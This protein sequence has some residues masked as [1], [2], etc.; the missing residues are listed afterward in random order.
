ML[1][2]YNSQTKNK[3][4]FQPLQTGKVQLYVCGS[5]VYDYCHLGHARMF[6]AFDLVVRYLR[7]RDYDV[8]YVRNITDIDDKIIARA[9]ENHE[10]IQAL[11]ERF[12]QAM[13]DD[14]AKL[15]LLSPDQEPKATEFIQPII[16]MISILIEKGYAYH[17]DHGDVLYAVEKFKNYGQLAHKDLEHLQVG[18]RVEVTEQKRNPLD[19]V[20]WK[21][22][23]PNEP[24]WDSP[25]GKGRPGWHIECSAMSTRCLAPHFDIHGGGGDLK[26]PHHENEVA[27]S[28]AATGE[29]FVNYWMHVGFVQ[30][31]K[32]KMSKSLGN[33]FTLR[34]VLQ[35][36]HPEILRYF[37]LASHYRSP[38]NYSTESLELAR[39]ALE[40]FYTSLRDVPVV[41]VVKGT[42][43]ER[44]FMQTM[45]DDFN[46]PEALAVL[47]DLT[48]EINRLKTEGMLEAA[49]QHAAT[50]R[51]LAGV[52]G[53]LQ[54][55]PREF[56]DTKEY[57]SQALILEIE[58][59]IKQREQA[60][61][62]KKWNEA[63]RLRQQ[64]SDKGVIL[65][66][67]AAGTRW[68]MS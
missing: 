46:T 43:H 32:E 63:D 33:F 61:S 42:E 7:F 30:I 45:D 25:W 66:D 8:K 51:Y 62:E 16:E 15:G 11:T 54:V 37:M 40:R 50:L 2:I 17:A 49:A 55:D 35:K 44:H 41:A 36:Y 14:L 48:H 34:D 21:Q 3:E 57:L 27:Q 67:S 23:K 68:R 52:L 60:R 53:I 18:A 19:F 59:L 20:L 29:K 26:F 64:L 58:T 10:T 31:N 28:E 24:S 5:T 65:E 47:F 1:T 22:A 9:N 12:T 39:G 56:L 4:L 13:H 6:T 38:I